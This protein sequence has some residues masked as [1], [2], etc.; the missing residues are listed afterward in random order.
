[1]SRE[2]IVYSRFLCS[3]ESPE[4]LY[5]VVVIYR[6]LFAIKGLYK[7]AINNSISILVLTPFI[8]LLHSQVK[9]HDVLEFYSIVTV[10]LRLL[11]YDDSSCAVNKNSPNQEVLFTYI[12]M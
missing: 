7:T 6:R 8:I 5:H 12:C 2:Y 11:S 1:M 4:G 9:K 3:P 10:R